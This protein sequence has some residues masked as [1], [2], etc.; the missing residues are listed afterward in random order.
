MEEFQHQNSFD[1][2]NGHR[3]KRS[4]AAGFAAPILLDIPMLAAMDHL[5][6][7]SFMV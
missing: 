1:C 4:K 7:V 3:S 5:S 6:L 2:G